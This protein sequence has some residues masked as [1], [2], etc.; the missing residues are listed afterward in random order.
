MAMYKPVFCTP[1]MKAGN[2][3]EITENNP[4][5]LSCKVNSSNTP[6]VGY[7]VRLY[8]ENL[9][10]IFP[11]DREDKITLLSEILSDDVKNGEYIEVPFIKCEETIGNINETN[12]QNTI[13]KKKQQG[14]SSYI[15]YYYHY[16]FY[17]PS[18][19]GWKP[20]SIN[21]ITSV[22]GNYS[23][24]YDVIDGKTIVPLEIEK[25][26]LGI[27]IINIK[28]QDY[29]EI[30]TGNY[31]QIVSKTDGR[32]IFKNNK[33]ID[34][35]FVAD[36]YYIRVL[37]DGYGGIINAEECNLLYGNMGNFITV[38]DSSAFHTGD[39]ITLESNSGTIIAEGVKILSVNNRE[40]LIR[41]DTTANVSYGDIICKRT[42]AS[43]LSNGKEYYWSITL[44]QS[45]IDSLSDKIDAENVV[46]AKQFLESS[47]LTIASGKV[48]GSNNIRIQSTNTKEQ[49]LDCFLQPVSISNLQ[50][51]VGK[52]QGWTIGDGGTISE[53]GNRVKIKNYVSPYGYY[54][55][56]TGENGVDAS[57]ITKDN[58][59]G[60]RVYKNTNDVNLMAATR[61]ATYLLD[62]KLQTDLENSVTVEW[63]ESAVN[64]SQS[65]WNEQ[66]YANNSSDIYKPFAHL[67]IM[68][69]FEPGT[70][71]VFNSQGDASFDGASPFNGIFTPQYS[72]TENLE[73]SYTSKIQY[74]ASGVFKKET[75]DDGQIKYY[76]EAVLS[77]S[78]DKRMKSVKVSGASYKLINEVIEHPFEIIDSSNI[79][80]NKSTATAKIYVKEAID[81]TQ[82]HIIYVEWD[83]NIY[84]YKVEVN[85]LRTTDANTWGTLYNKVVFVNGNNYEALGIGEENVSTAGV[86]NQTSIKFQIEKP[87]ELFPELVNDQ[88]KYRNTIGLIFYNTFSSIDGEDNVLYISPFEGIKPKMLWYET[89]NFLNRFFMISDVN[90]QYY[91]IKYKN[92]FNTGVNIL[93]R[94][95]YFQTD[96]T[97]Y[98]IKTSF[99][100]SNLN[101]FSFQDS[102][103]VTISC[104]TKNLGTII[105]CSATFDQNNFLH[106]RSYYWEMYKTSGELVYS[107][108]TKYDKDIS[109]DFSNIGYIVDGTIKNT[110]I[111]KI[112][113][114]ST[115]GNYY[116]FSNQ[117]NIAVAESAT[118]LTTESDSTK[119]VQFTKDCDK[120][121]NNIM[122][123]GEAHNAII[124]K[125]EVGISLYKLYEHD[126][127]VETIIDYSVGNRRNYNYYIFWTITTTQPQTSTN[128]RISFKN[129]RHNF[130]AWSIVDIDSET[131]EFLS[132]W[133]LR[134]G[135]NGGGV[136]QNIS[137]NKID[138]MSRYSSFSHGTTN[139]LSGSVTCYLGRD[140]IMSDNSYEWYAE[141]LPDDSQFKDLSSN[142]EIAMIEAWKYV[143]ASPGDKL[144]RDIKGNMYLAQITESSITTKEEWEKMP[145]EIQF[146]WCETPYGVDEYDNFV[147][148]KNING[149]T[150]IPKV[151]RVTSN[152]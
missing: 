130:D 107:G 139:H 52:E 109:E 43:K 76:I 116:Q 138:N 150:Y 71:V 62:E 95:Q 149:I 83:I 129:I 56:T 127:E 123:R 23:S 20:F 65:Y 89:S 19:N 101:P 134:Y 69:V 79:V 75:G 18:Q 125:E 42:F 11:V 91:Y 78:D 35:Y 4:F 33:I 47:D 151:I 3:N 2:L 133:K 12:V 9:N 100:S 25:T 85:W 32:V 15:Y 128:Y 108:S 57:V 64:A 5:V 51:E 72:T 31:V 13:V 27:Y 63:K 119:Y 58:A 34:K 14:G 132:E 126:G 146:G 131:G 60:F 38:N 41:I 90:T 8:D 80:I 24:N 114:L 84:K 103:N 53:V 16:N 93:P 48:L 148:T 54:Y 70:R 140:I 124:F 122:L 40:N 45:D 82:N 30:D 112:V 104:A 59:N 77:L 67:G 105:H 66:Y 29:D 113:F 61:R 117:V 86:L 50:Y 97:E 55:L 96:V 120:M 121:S 118:D 106:W 141:K 88:N 68:N 6:V 136:T 73:D 111:F 46:S 142:E 147:M 143:C 145:T 26:Q 1:Y 110:Y 137:K 36:S 39:I 115:D 44:Y 74:G 144:I 37:I 98:D 28:K 99:M 21:Q 87:I 17:N 10:Q 135:L 81:A 49:V 22:L 92:V 94:P 102:P 7:S 152:K